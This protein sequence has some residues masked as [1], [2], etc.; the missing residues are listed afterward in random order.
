MLSMLA[1]VSHTNK[2]FHC[3]HYSGIAAAA[4]PC[5]LRLSQISPTSCTRA[6]DNAHRCNVLSEQAP[7]WNFGSGRCGRQKDCPHC[8]PRLISSAGSHLASSCSHGWKHF[9]HQLG[10]L[11]TRAA[12][13]LNESG[14]S[15]EQSSPRAC[16]SRS[17]GTLATAASAARA[18]SVEEPRNSVPGGALAPAPPGRSTRL[19]LRTAPAARNWGWSRKMGSRQTAQSCRPAS[20]GTYTQSG[21]CHLSPTRDG[22][23]SR[24]IAAARACGPGRGRA[25]GR[26]AARPRT[27]PAPAH[28]C[29][30][31]SGRCRHPRNARAGLAPVAVTRGRG[32]GTC[33]GHTREGRRA[34][35]RT[36]GSAAAWPRRRGCRASRWRAPRRV[37]RAAAGGRAA[38][39]S[40]GHS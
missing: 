13:A 14:S 3:A 31:W 19:R 22:R 4:V 12:M 18:S 29:Q 37:R 24:S 6:A 33:P 10:T 38:Q 23:S 1:R 25:R 9:A 34:T 40:R 17:T 7:R 11:S 28:A 26:R 27:P 39:S 5:P 15:T 8:A 36:H 16:G 2:T 35:G 32:L 21:R 30:C 20:Q